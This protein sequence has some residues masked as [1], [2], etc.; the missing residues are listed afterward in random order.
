MYLSDGYRLGMESDT[1]ADWQL[2]APNYPLT[3]N[4]TSVP[5]GIKLNT[6]LSKGHYSL[7]PSWRHGTGSNWLEVDLLG[8]YL[9][10]GL[11]VQGDGVEQA[12]TTTFDIE[13][14]LFGTMNQGGGTYNRD[15]G[16]LVSDGQRLFNTLKPGQNDRH[17]PNG[18][19]KWIFVNEN[20]PTSIKI[21]LKFI[22]KGPI[23]NSP[24]LFQIMASRRPGDK[25]LS[26]TMMVNLLTHICVS[27]LQWINSMP[28]ENAA[29]TSNCE[30]SNS[31]Q[32]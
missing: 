10:K 28:L 29:M 22:P 3:T 13:Y 17:S 4:L 14:S 31:Y 24:A 1:V 11:I 7:A 16:T 20:A 6:D 21:S 9:I 27:R 18:I 5:P 32:R 26:E 30:V 2:R 25:Q 15:P 8:A 23:S 12:W 19:F